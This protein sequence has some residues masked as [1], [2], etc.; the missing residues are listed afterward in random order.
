MILG[1]SDW[2]GGGEKLGEAIDAALDNENLQ[3]SE[4]I[5]AAISAAGFAIVGPEITEDMRALSAKMEDG[6]YCGVDEWWSRMLAAGDLAR[7]PK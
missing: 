6:P 7:N 3:G 4:D 5:V 1:D 2:Y